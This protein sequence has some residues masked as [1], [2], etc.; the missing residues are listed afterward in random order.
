MNVVILQIPEPE[1]TGDGPEKKITRLAIGVEGGFEPDIG[2]PKY[3]YTDKYNVVVLPG[4]YTFP[5]PDPSLPEVV[6]ISISFSLIVVSLLYLPINRVKN[7]SMLDIR[8]SQLF[9][10][11]VNLFKSF[12]VKKSVQAIINAESPFKMAEMAALQGTWDGERREISV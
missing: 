1:V 7:G 3:T 11:T 10:L 8:L 9:E 5:W 4:F 6:N 12:Q 2:K